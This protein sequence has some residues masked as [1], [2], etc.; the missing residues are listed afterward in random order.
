[1]GNG[2]IE[3]SYDDETNYLELNDRG[4][5][6]YS[7]FDSSEGTAFYSLEELQKMPSIKFD[8]EKTADKVKEVYEDLQD[9]VD[10][11]D[12]QLNSMKDVYKQLG[13]DFYYVPVNGGKTVLV[14]TEDYH[15]VEKLEKVK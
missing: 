4:I 15:L 3:R 5:L 8:Q 12:Y 1:M 10:S 2:K 7:E 14:F 13:S 6:T 11:Q 9:A